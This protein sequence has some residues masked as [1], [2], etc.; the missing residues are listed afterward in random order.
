VDL[1][2]EQPELPSFN[3]SL[4]FS[5]YRCA[6]APSESS[7]TCVLPFSFGLQSSNFYVVTIPIFYL[8]FIPAS[9]YIFDFYRLYLQ[10]TP[11]ILASNEA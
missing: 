10:A 11:V 7:I 1:P 2:V 4:L 3:L 9:A 6:S 5:Q 8:I